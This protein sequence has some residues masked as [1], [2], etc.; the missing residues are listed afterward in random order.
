MCPCHHIRFTWVQRWHL[1][2]WCRWGAEYRRRV[3]ST[4]AHS[5]LFLPVPL[6]CCRL[7][8]AALG[9]LSAIFRYQ[10]WCNKGD[11]LRN[12]RF[13]AVA[14]AT[15][16]T[17]KIWKEWDSHENRFI[18]CAGRSHK[19]ICSVLYSLS[20]KVSNQTGYSCKQRPIYAI[21][22]HNCRFCTCSAV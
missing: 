14:T 12:I 8:L 6:Q 3:R 5:P 13:I 11:S 20:R 15:E 16:K 17:W 10:R 2:L 22:P 21:N 4:S 9:S 1:S 7:P 18:Y 19:I